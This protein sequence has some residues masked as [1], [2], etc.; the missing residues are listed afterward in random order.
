MDIVL[1]DVDL[2]IYP[3]GEKFAKTI[4]EVAGTK[5]DIRV[6]INNAGMSHDMPVT[7]EDMTTEE[8]E[9]I[10]GVNTCGVLRVTKETLPYLLSDSYFPHTFDG[11]CR[12]KKRLIVNVGSF[13]GYAPTPVSP[14][15][16][17]TNG[18]FLQRILEQKRFYQHGPSQQN[19][20]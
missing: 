5:G 17:I 18:S 16:I 6:L 19:T 11:D 4:K 2:G 9:G 7:F 15:L 10:V 8:M 13:A 20:N 3:L 12:K 14:S 1:V